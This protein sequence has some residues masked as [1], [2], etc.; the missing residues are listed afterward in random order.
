MTFS[1]GNSINLFRSLNFFLS[2]YRIEE[3]ERS[4]A[5]ALFYLF[6]EDFHSGT[7]NIEIQSTK[8]IAA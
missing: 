1:E 7:Q 3:R 5:R 8:V 6:G 2:L 4:E